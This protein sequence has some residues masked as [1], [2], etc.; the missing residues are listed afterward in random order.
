MENNNNVMVL[1]RTTK[2]GIVDIPKNAVLV[3]ENVIT[4]KTKIRSKVGVWFTMPWICFNTIIYKTPFTK[5]YGE[6]KYDTIDMP[7]VKVKPQITFRITK[8][9]VF[10]KQVCGRDVTKVEQ[11]SGRMESIYNV[12][13]VAIRNII[14]TCTF[15]ELKNFS[16]ITEKDPT[17]PKREKYV[18][19]NVV[20]ETRDKVRNE[21]K[22]IENLYGIKIIKFGFDDVTLHD[23]VQNAQLAA[24]KA[25]FDAQVLAEEAEGKRLAALKE[26]KAIEIK[27]KAY[28]EAGLSN[29][30]IGKILMIEKNTHGTVIMGANN[31]EALLSQLLNEKNNNHASNN[32]NNTQNDNQDINNHGS[33]SL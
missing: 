4:K 1:A 5:Q 8:P 24:E 32:Q 10:Y 16:L 19:K 3:V 27:I 22:S 23:T 17:N 26:A 28:R 9:S 30:V 12:I 15:D 18:I 2:T 29:E 13:K 14:I 20:K 21:F 25:K 31:T 6:E 11:N 7:E 33:I